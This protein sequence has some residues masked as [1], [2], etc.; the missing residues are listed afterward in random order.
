MNYRTKKYYC[1]IAVFYTFNNF[2]VQPSSW[3]LRKGTI[4]FIFIRLSDLLE[5]QRALVLSF[6]KK[7]K[8]E[9]KELFTIFFK[10]Q[11][12][13][14]LILIQQNELI[15]FLQDNLLAYKNFHWKQNV[16]FV[17]VKDFPSTLAFTKLG[18]QPTRT[19]RTRE[20]TAVD[21]KSR[22]LFKRREWMEG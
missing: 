15:V 22:P 13:S 12:N 19:M 9:K 17:L 10:I 16:L 3:H 11:L 18:V 5:M 1:F 6:F 20:R 14:Y 2:L 7:R 8:K 21:Q 4:F